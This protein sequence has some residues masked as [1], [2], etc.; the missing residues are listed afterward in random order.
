MKKISFISQVV[1]AVIVGIAFGLWFPDLTA[2][3]SIFGQIFLKLMQMSIPILIFGQIVY[4]LG[5]IEKK[6]ISK[7]GGLTIAI[8][9]VST[10][11]AAFWGILFGSLFKPGQGVSISLASN[12]A[13]AAQELNL[14]ETF[15]EFFP[16]NIFASLSS[17]SIIQI[18][19]FSLV[20][21]T[22][23]NIYVQNHANNVILKILD[24]INDIVMIVIR[25]VMSIAPIGI[26]S[27]VADTV[28]EAGLSVILPLLKYLIVYAF[29]T[30]L[31][32]GIWIT[33]VKIYCKRSVS[34]LVKGIKEMSVVAL[35]TGSSAI[36]LSTAIDGAKKYLKVDD[37]ITNLVLPLGVSLNSNGAAMHM[38]ITVVTVAQM[39]SFNLGLD[40][41]IYLGILASLV[42]LA[43]SVAPGSSIVSLAIIFPQM[44]IPIEAVALFAGVDYFVGMIRT[45]LNV[46]SDVF[47]AMLVAQSVGKKQ[48]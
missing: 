41:L 47:T 15:T 22:A 48:N 39:Y 6:D 27:L 28:S 24:E 26:F 29:A 3:F 4:A 20:F 23:I 42:S 33:V 9:A 1:L 11:I 32:L 30:F 45:I 18:I 14:S 13:I 2:Y 40:K 34:F 16:S 36:T 43:N 37:Y 7:I 44:G 19:V 12:E 38:A 35:T 10:L 5:S 8:F 17:G 46:D 25:M 31:F 21:G